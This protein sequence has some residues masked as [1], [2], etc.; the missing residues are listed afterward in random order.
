MT[1]FGGQNAGD[2]VVWIRCEDSSR[3]PAIDDLTRR[4]NHDGDAVRIVTTQRNDPAMSHPKGGRALRV[5]LATHRPV[6]VILVGGVIDTQILSA[7]DATQTP[8]IAVESRPDTLRE[9]TGGWFRAS[10]RPALSG[11]ASAFASDARA[12]DTLRKLG[13]P[14]GQVHAI[15]P[16]EQAARILPHSDAER[17]EIAQFLRNRP[18]WL[19]RAAQ[20]SDAEVLAVAHRHAS[21]KSHRLL[22][23]VIPERP[24]FGADFANTFSDM[25]YFV[26]LR[27]RGDEPDEASQIYIADLDGEDGL[28]LRL[29]PIC[30]AVGTLTRGAAHDPFEAAALGSVVIHGMKTDPYA[31]RFRRLLRA[32][33]SLG[34]ADP[35]KL[36]LTVEQLLS[37]D[38]AAEMAVAGWEVTSSGAEISNRLIGLIQDRLDTVGR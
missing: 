29:A 17:H 28:W 10:A 7:C 35:A 15:G 8:V 27:S 20:L 4:L 11:V 30:F 34:I 14:S 26:G 37:A 25:G 16:L 2:P 21:R 6:L 22:L 12:A 33:A 9:M 31:E 19:V 24:I 36:G 32:G 38:R 5:F 3:L 18:V 13:V 1:A 23:V